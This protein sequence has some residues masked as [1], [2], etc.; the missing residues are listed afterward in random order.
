MQN[1]NKSPKETGHNIWFCVGT[2]CKIRAKPFHSFCCVLT[3]P[4]SREGNV[5]PHPHPLASAPSE[6]E[7]ESERETERERKGERVRQRERERERERELPNPS[8]S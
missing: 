6:R 1:A 5:P 8:R 3:S 7:R 4:D 2:R